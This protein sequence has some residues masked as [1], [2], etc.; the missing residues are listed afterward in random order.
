MNTRH[1]RLLSLVYLERARGALIAITLSM[2]PVCILFAK[3]SGYQ[4]A[5]LALNFTVLAAFYPFAIGGVVAKS[6][7]DGSLAFLA[8]LPISASDHARSWLLVVMLLSLPI[9]LVVMVAGYHP[10]LAL[11]GSM[12]AGVGLT[13]MAC[14]ISAVMGMLAV[15]LSAP[16]AMAMSRFM[17][18]MGGLILLLAAVGKLYEFQPTAFETLVHSPYFFPVLSLLGWGAA[19]AGFWWSWQRVGHF[20]T[21]YVGDPPSA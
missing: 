5:E 14:A 3:K 6:K 10:P 7:A 11:R 16:P 8:S 1:L 19:A 12:L 20:M 13:S 4:P 21:S 17:S 2:T 18:V 15:Q 9:A